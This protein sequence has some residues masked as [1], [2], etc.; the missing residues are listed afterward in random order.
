MELLGDFRSP[1]PR[2]FF[3]FKPCVR[4]VNYLRH[5]SATPIRK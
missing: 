5:G 2:I 3:D 1:A 4:S